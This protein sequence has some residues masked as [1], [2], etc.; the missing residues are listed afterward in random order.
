MKTRIIILLCTFAVGLAVVCAAADPVVV[1]PDATAF[2]SSDWTQLLSGIAVLEAT[3]ADPVLGSQ[4]G[5]GAFGWTSQQ[6]SRFTAWSLADRGYPVY[7]VSSGAQTWVLVGLALPGQIVWIPIEATP[8][9]GQVQTTL[10]RIPYASR[11]TSSIRYIDRY[12]AYT[13]VAG[14]PTNAAPIAQI[15]TDA[16]SVKVGDLVTLIARESRD[17]D[18]QIALYVWCVDGLPC[19]A[20]PSWSFVFRVTASGRQ[21]AHLIV[22]DNLGRPSRAQIALTSGSN[23][24][25][26]GEDKDNDCGCGGG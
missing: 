5:P 6:F 10:G 23:P 7:L 21:T 4:L 17:S 8:Q 26:V 24:P 16:A 11:S 1:A 15:E 2:G 3:L 18:G 13:S 20:S 12:A 9:T 25:G 22:I 19:S 14:L